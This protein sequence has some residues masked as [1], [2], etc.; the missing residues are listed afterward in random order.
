MVITEIAAKH[1]GEEREAKEEQVRKQE[2]ELIPRRAL[3]S[4]IIDLKEAPKR[5]IICDGC[6]KRAGAIGP[7]IFH[8]PRCEI[9]IRVSP[10][11]GR[12]E[13]TESQFETLLGGERID[14]DQLLGYGESSALEPPPPDEY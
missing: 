8:C 12:V 10:G 7:M 11:L 2:Y 14:F 4:T 6:A 13:Y 5:P 1:I 3:Y 9:I